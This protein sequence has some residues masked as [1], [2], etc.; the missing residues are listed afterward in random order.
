[1]KTICMIPLDVP[2]KDWSFNKKACED[3]RSLVCHGI[4]RLQ[5]IYLREIAVQIVSFR[6]WNRNRGCGMFGLFST[7]KYLH[8]TNVAEIQ[9]NKLTDHETQAGD[10]HNVNSWTGRYRQIWLIGRC[11]L[12][13][14]YLRDTKKLSANLLAEI[15]DRIRVDGYHFT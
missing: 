8:L 6:T 12:S 15:P 10:A 5:C 7:V 13:F 9:L 2:V 11:V 14:K 1:M 4:C 3:P